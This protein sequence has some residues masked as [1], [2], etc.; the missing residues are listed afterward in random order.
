ME[1]SSIGYFTKTHGVKGQ[2]ILRDEEDF[3][4]EGLNAF[5]LDANGGKAPYFIEELTEASQGLI[6]KLEEVD[7]IEKARALIK[8]TVYVETRFLLQKE[9]EATYIDFE[10]IDDKLGSLGKVTGTSDNGQ[11]D[12][13]SLNYKGKEIILPLVEELILKIDESAKIIWYSTPEGLIDIYL[14]E[15]S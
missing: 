12:L 2:L 7:T 3:E 6:I 1:F 13:L 8:K 10:V 15:S 11:Q 5:F 4:T 14:E 9:E